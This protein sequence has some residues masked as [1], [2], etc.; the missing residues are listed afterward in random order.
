MKSSFFHLTHD[1]ACQILQVVLELVLLLLKFLLVDWGSTEEVKHRARLGVEDKR[2]AMKSFVLVQE[3]GKGW[4]NEAFTHLAAID[5]QVL[6]VREQVR[7]SQH[8]KHHSWLIG[9]QEI[10]L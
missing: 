7:A 5:S 10:A 1:T 4:Q 2:E 3:T 8:V 9:E 6:Q